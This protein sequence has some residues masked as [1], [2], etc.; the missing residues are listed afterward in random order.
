MQENNL[1]TFYLEEIK[2]LDKWLE[3]WLKSYNFYSKYLHLHSFKKLRGIFMNVFKQM[4]RN[5]NNNKMNELNWPLQNVLLNWSIAMW[6]LRKKFAHYY[7]FVFALFFV[8]CCIEKNTNTMYCLH[9]KK[10][11]MYV[12]STKFLQTFWSH[13]WIQKLLY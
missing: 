2:K 10:T 4:Q 1:I 11:L 6:Q 3:I 9:R 13:L 8:V 7:Y 12:G 5:N